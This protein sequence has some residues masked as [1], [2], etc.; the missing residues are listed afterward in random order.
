[1]MAY[2][3]KNRRAPTVIGFPMLLFHA[4]LLL[5]LCPIVFPSLWRKASNRGSGSQWDIATGVN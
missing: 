1:M 3:A 5:V 2:A 4:V